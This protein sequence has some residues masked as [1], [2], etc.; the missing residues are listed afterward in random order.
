MTLKAIHKRLLAIKVEATKIINDADANAGGKLTDAGKASFDALMSEKDELE[1]DAKR[2]EQLEG[3]STGQG[4]VVAPAAPA[5]PEATETRVTGGA[6][7]IEQ[8]PM[9]GFDSAADFGRAVKSAGIPGRQLDER[10]TILGAPSNTH[11]EVGSSDGYMV[12]PK[13]A[14]EVAN[15]VMGEESILDKLSPE[16]TES[17]T[18]ELPVDESTPWGSTGIQ[19][20]WASEGT[21]M[22]SSKLATVGRNLSLHKLYAFV[23]ASDE[24][25]E[26]AP[27]LE[28]R[29]TI[30]SA[31][32]IRWK[33]DEAVVNGDGVGK[34]QGWMGADC[35]V[36]VAKETSQTAATVV[37]GN[38]LKMRARL[39]GNGA[40]AF[41]LVHQ[42]VIPQLGLMTIGDQPMWITRDAGL[43]EAMV[44]RL[45]GLPIF[46]SEHCQVVGTAGD[47]QLVAPNGYYSAIKQGGIKFAAS[48]HLYFDYGLAA[49]RWTFRLAGQ[50]LLSAAVSQAK[51]SET[52]SHFIVTA[53]RS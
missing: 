1:A 47:I 19:A 11:K 50:P 42:S 53:V 14:S 16:P 39:L 36:S 33:A 28:S 43:Q 6:P 34:P 25:L 24:L 52:L 21:Q 44:G 4:R 2:L 22:T 27:R 23:N 8:D 15:L 48:M 20:Y 9:R 40:G 35:L 18:V 12:P 46:V 38:V 29:L 30:K 5:K 31:E 7:R 26:D 10:L 37:A 45:L 41:W 51:G 13:I 17:N 32:A 3:M 49:F